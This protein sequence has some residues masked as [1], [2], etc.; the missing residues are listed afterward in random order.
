MLRTDHLTWLQIDNF[1]QLKLLLWDTFLVTLMV[2]FVTRL[3][4][5]HALTWDL[6]V[7]PARS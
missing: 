3:I 6:L 7:L 5:A 4:S 2:L 1:G